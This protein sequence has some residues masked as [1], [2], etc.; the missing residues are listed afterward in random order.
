MTRALGALNM[1]LW[2]Q[3]YLINTMQYLEK[4]G[5]SNNAM[6]PSFVSD[7]LWND[8]PDGLIRVRCRLWNQRFFFQLKQVTFSG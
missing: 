1:F 4:N 5:K 3:D 8:W 7:K 2:T 6:G